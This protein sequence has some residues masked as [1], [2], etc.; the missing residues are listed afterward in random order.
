MSHVIESQLGHGAPVF[1]YDF[2]LSQAA[3]AKIRRDT[4]PVA[5]R[6]EVYIRGLEIANGY[7]ELQDPIEQQHRFEQDLIKRKAMQQPS[8]PI[9][10]RLVAAL[11]QGFPCCAGVALGVDRLIMLATEQTCISKVIAFPTERA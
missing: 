4:V 9:D 1:V 2:P 11:T 3:L 8:V 10:T 6:F 5:E 7:H